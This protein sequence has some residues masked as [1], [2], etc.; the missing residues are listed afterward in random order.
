M[1]RHHAAAPPTH[2]AAT[3][4]KTTSE[5]TEVEHDRAPAEKILNAEGTVTVIT[6]LRCWRAQKSKI[7]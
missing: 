4:R 5:Q 1:S 7:F 3:A 2:P 6:T